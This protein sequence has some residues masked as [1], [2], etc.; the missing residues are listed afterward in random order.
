VP[1]VN[2]SSYAEA[3]LVAGG[4]PAATWQS[5][6]RLET[7]LAQVPRLKLLL[8]A[9]GTGRRPEST[10]SGLLGDWPKPIQRLTAELAQAGA[11]DEFPAIVWSFE[12]LLGKQGY[13]TVAMTSAKPLGRAEVNAVLSALPIDRKLVLIESNVDPDLIG[14]L[15]VSLEGTEYDLSIGGALE[16]LAATIGAEA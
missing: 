16:R 9:A 11:L 6:T 2:P 13:R 5:L 7:A 8:I 10:I 4:D 14:G 15:R 3:L 12:S 1:D